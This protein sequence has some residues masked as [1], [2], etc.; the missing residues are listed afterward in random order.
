MANARTPKPILPPDVTI[1]SVRWQIDEDIEKALSNRAIPSQCPPDKMY[2]PEAFRTQLITWAHSSLTAGHP[3]ETRNHKLLAQRYWWESMMKDIHFF[4]SSCSTC[5][6]CK[7]PKTLPAGKLMPLPVPN[8]PWSHIA[9]DF[10]TDLPES[11]GFTTIL[12]VVD[13][14]SRAVRFIPF[15]ALPSAFQTAQ[16]LFQHVSHF[17]PTVHVPSVGS[18]L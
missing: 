17:W 15:A 1:S 14:F 10:V 4:V 8:R 5:S 6:Q 13:R 2:V 3:G 7:T 16:A 9:V 12:T 11:Q 18:F